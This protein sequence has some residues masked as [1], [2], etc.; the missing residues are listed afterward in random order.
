[1]R[2]QTTIPP[3]RD[4]TVRLTGADGHGYVFEPDAEGVLSCDIE[5]AETLADLLAGAL[6]FPA[7]VADTERALELV[8]QVDEA[9]DEGD[10]PGDAPPVEAKTP[11]AKRAPRKAK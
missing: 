10:E 2:L 6:F 11:A 4:G 3:R 1:M 9:D 7:D 5:D 8:R